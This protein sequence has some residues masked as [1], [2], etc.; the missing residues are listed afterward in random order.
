M[1]FSFFS[2]LTALWSVNKES[3]L[4]VLLIGM[5]F[6]FLSA[7]QAIWRPLKSSIFAK[8]AGAHAIASAKIYVLLYIIPL[9]IFYSYLVDRLRRHQLLYVFSL[10]HGIGGAFFV[11]LFSYFPLTAFQTNPLLHACGWAFYFLMESFSAFLST[12]FWSFANSVN[13]PQEAQHTYGFLVLGSKLGGIFSAG[14]LYLALNSV[15]KTTQNTTFTL[16]PQTLL[17]GCSLLIASVVVVF[18]LIKSVP[19]EQ[20]RGY[21]EEKTVES[22]PDPEKNIKKVFFAKILDGLSSIIK[23]PYVAGI[24]SLVLLYEIMIAILE[25]RVLI[26]ADAAYA[27]TEALTQYY[28]LQYMCMHGIGL[29]FVLF[30]TVP[31]QRLT[32][33][34]VAL[35]AVPILSSLLIS[36]T[37]FW[38]TPTCFFGALVLIKALNYAV[39]HPTRETLYIPTTRSIK[40]KTKAWI[41][42]FGSRAAKALGN[43]FNLLTGCCGGAILNQMSAIVNAC[44]IGAWLCIASGLGVAFVQTIKDKKVI[45]EEDSS[46]S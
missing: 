7:C 30:G 42:A 13:T 24:T 10:F 41:D 19:Q 28:A 11:T 12:V 33:I 27:S 32:N 4:K 5:V 14:S 26:A 1:K 20:M 43:V 38:P 22:A 3:R 17:V 44:V 18:L 21:Q 23:Y 2:D 8:I 37:Y 6:F 25:Y 9:L 39:N 34:R 45:G 29:F 40:F 36:A 15:V 16:L 35:F 31:L 46:K